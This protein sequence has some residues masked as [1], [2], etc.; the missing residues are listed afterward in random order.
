[1]VVDFR[2]FKD[3]F[4]ARLLVRFPGL[5]RR[6]EQTNEFLTF[7]DSPWA[8]LNKPLKESKICLLT[9]AGVHLKSQQPFDM[10]NPKGDASFRE[11]PW[12]SERDQLKITHNYFDHRDADQDINVVL[13]LERVQILQQMGEIGQ[14]NHRHFSFMGH[15]IKDQ[16]ERLLQETTPKVVELLRQ[17]QVDVV[18][19]S[20]A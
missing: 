20:P 7:S 19:L 9:T 18:I 17:D 11:I 1:M 5:F 6:W 10:K 16:L 13:P 14:V 2:R 3:Q 4:I 15:I 12:E 8:P